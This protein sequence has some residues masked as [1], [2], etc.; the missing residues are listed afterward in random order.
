MRK[1]EVAPKSSL[2]IC[3][4]RGDRRWRSWSWVGMGSGGRRYRASAL[5]PFWILFLRHVAWISCSCFPLLSVVGLGHAFEDSGSK[6]SS[7]SGGVRPTC[8]FSLLTFKMEANIFSVS[9]RA[10]KSSRGEYPVTSSWSLACS[11]FAN[12][13]LR[14]PWCQNA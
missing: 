1:E 10:L 9:Q 5:A 6:N 12:K 4:T 8:S 7:L 2:L 3:E 13:P 14:G 11:L